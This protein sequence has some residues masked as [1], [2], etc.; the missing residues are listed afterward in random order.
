MNN[1]TVAGCLWVLVTGVVIVMQ[2][3][4]EWYIH[5]FATGTAALGYLTE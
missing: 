2:Q 4:A 1:R 5:A 3:P